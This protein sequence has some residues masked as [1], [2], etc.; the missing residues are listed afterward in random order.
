[1]FKEIVRLITFAMQLDVQ[2]NA[3]KIQLVVYQEMEMGHKEIVVAMHFATLMVYVLRYAQWMG[4]RQATVMEPKAIA[5]LDSFATPTVNV[6]ISV[7]KIQPRAMAM[8]PKEIA[9]L[10]N[11]VTPT[12]HAHQVRRGAT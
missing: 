7:R 12:V 5:Q 8:E 6:L 9:M 2:S 1:M 11:C 10:V 3:Q 4:L